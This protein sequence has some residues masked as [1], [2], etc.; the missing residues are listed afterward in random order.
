MDR[1]VRRLIWHDALPK[2]HIRQLQDFRSARKQLELAE[3]F[4]A[5]LR[6]SR[7]SAFGLVQDSIRHKHGKPCARVISCLALAT[8]SRDGSASR[9]LGIVVS[10][11]MLAYP[12]PHSIVTE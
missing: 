7:V 5:F 12:Y 8:R 4:D 2:I 10:Y 3:K 11:I 1:I 6:G 9:K